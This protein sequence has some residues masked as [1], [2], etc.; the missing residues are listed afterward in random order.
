MRLYETCQHSQTTSDT[1][2]SFQ[3]RMGLISRNHPLIISDKTASSMTALAFIFFSLLVD[4]VD[5][6]GMFSSDPLGLQTNGR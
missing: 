2:I 6:Y 1:L 3:N 5:P 4:F